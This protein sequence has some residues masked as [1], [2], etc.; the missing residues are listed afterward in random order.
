VI[1]AALLVAVVVTA[2]AAL[3]NLVWLPWQCNLRI[4]EIRARTSAAFS[5]ELP[6]AD[7]GRIARESLA[8]YGGCPA[9]CGANVDWFMARAAN[10]RVLH[11]LDAA[12][13]A[14]REAL[15]RD[16]RPELY[17]N[18]AA[19]ELA[20]GRR[21]AAIRLYVR[22]MLFDPWLGHDIEDPIVKEEVL[23]RVQAARPGH[24]EYFRAHMS[25]PLSDFENARPD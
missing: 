8:M 7:R 21:E 16:R 11:A 12:R 10:Q 4:V 1:R 9:G 19:T 2:L 24:E 3:R 18:L 22:A 23:R 5:G 17:L 14:Y 20:A 25:I 15:T 6:P 13:V